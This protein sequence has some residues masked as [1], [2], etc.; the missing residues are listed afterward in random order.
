MLKKLLSITAILSAL[1]LPHQAF[2]I[3]I[4]CV[5]TSDGYVWGWSCGPDGDLTEEECETAVNSNSSAA[6]CYYIYAIAPPPASPDESMQS[7]SGDGER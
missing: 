1:L 6:N 4:E 5:Q 2:A 7:S 3:Q